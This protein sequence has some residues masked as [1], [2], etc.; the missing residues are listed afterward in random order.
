LNL[1][2]HGTLSKHCFQFQDF[3]F[4]LSSIIYTV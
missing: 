1:T 2:L 4:S 3:Q